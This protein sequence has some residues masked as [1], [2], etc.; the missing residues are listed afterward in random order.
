MFPALASP[1]KRD[2][3]ASNW[4]KNLYSM[5]WKNFKWAIVEIGYNHKRASKRRVEKCSTRRKKKTI[6]IYWIKT[7]CSHYSND[8]AS[9]QTAIIDA[10][11]IISFSSRIEL[12]NYASL[13]TCKW[14]SAT[15]RP[16]PHSRS[17]G[18]SCAPNSR[19]I[20]GSNSR[21]WSGT[22]ASDPRHLLCRLK[23]RRR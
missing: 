4:D 19:W 7:G 11:W 14:S 8:I 1:K 16:R 15:C 23:C 2:F 10:R 21:G 5:L 20:L 3:P 17:A 13:L 22:A 12:C 6:K 18:A 9:T